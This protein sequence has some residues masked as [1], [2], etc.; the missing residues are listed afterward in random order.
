MQT[1]IRNWYDIVIDGNGGQASK[2]VG[3]IAPFVNLNTTMDSGRKIL[4]NIYFDISN[5]QIR[6]SKGR[7]P[8]MEYQVL[9]G[10]TRQIN[11]LIGDTDRNDISKYT[12]SFI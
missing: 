5:N 1:N 7:S 12:F 8:I 3:T 10:T 2:K 4:S 9:V 11:G 6:M